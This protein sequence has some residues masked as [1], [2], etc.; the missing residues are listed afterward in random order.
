MPQATSFRVIAGWPRSQ[1]HRARARFSCSSS[2]V[3]RVRRRSR[4]VPEAVAGRSSASVSVIRAMQPQQ[5]WKSVK[6]G[7]QIATRRA[8]KIRYSDSRSADRSAGCKAFPMRSW[9][10]ESPQ[11]G[12]QWEC[13]RGRH[14]EPKVRG[15]P[16]GINAW[17]D[18]RASAGIG[19]VT[20]WKLPRRGRRAECRDS[21]DSRIGGVLSDGLSEAVP[22]SLSGRTGGLCGVVHELYR[23]IRRLAS[24]SLDVTGLFSCLAEDSEA[25]NAWSGQI[26]VK[27]RES[28]SAEHDFTREFCTLLP[29]RSC[30]SRRD[31]VTDEEWK[32]VILE[33][34]P[35]HPVGMLDSWIVLYGYSGLAAETMQLALRLVFDL[36]FLVAIPKSRLLL[37]PPLRNGTFETPSKSRNA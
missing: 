9:P 20:A 29:H 35:S 6:D 16:R 12:R 5:V 37:T 36:C 17:T 32:A 4:Q 28:T 2:G 19:G 1:L 34:A 18:L 8:P 3:G 30:R 15:R 23:A 22:S 25:I 21:Y 7:C 26:L 14:G 31:L 10:R 27:R 13:E 11:R 33:S 24:G